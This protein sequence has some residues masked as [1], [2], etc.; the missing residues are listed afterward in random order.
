MKHFYLISMTVMVLLASCESDAMIDN[1][2]VQN[3][4]SKK[5][6]LVTLSS[7][8]TV[9][10]K[11]GNYVWQDDI[12]LSDEQLKQLDSTGDIFTDGQEIGKE[13]DGILV[14][15]ASGYSY[16]PED[17]KT[18]STA[19]YQRRIICGLWCDLLTQKRVQE[20]H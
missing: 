13:D 3:V 17:V 1:Q 20:R 10:Y 12:L 15:P 18:R 14:N 2:S 11:D 16:I 7:G 19:I 6:E 9:E 5:K 4:E 8:A